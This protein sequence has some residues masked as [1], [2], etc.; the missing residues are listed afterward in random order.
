MKW[1][2]IGASNIAAEY[3]I[4]AIR[5]QG[6]GHEILAV[7]STTNARAD[8]FARANNIPTGTSDLQK[9]LADQN[10]DA[11]YISSTNEK[12]HSQTMAAIAAGKHVLCEKPLALNLADAASMVTAAEKA[13]VVLATNHHL[14]NAGSHLAIKEQ[15]DAGRIGTVLSIRIYHAVMLPKKLRGWRVND[16][17]AGGGVILD[18]V[19]HDADTVRFYLDEDPV[20]VTATAQCSD[21][22]EEVEDGVMSIWQMPSGA[23]IQTHEAFNHPHAGSGIEVHGTAGSIFARGVMT[24]RPVGQI[25]I[26]DEKGKH[27]LSFSNHNLYERSLSLFTAAVAG[28]A[29][30]AASGVDGVKS[31]ALALAVKQAAVTNARVQVDYAGR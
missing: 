11:V 4:D 6:S 23:M 5:A 22:S 28:N 18:I 12:H 7:M 17:A 27:S 1:G 19:V 14:R 29:A 21:M 30:P 13:K 24:Q 9:L 3:M 10:I 2:L 26:V 31:L 25:D 16:A 8:E 15:I 20:A